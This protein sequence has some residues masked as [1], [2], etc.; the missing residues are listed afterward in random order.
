MLKVSS[1]LTDTPSQSL[2]P[3]ID[4]SVNDD[5]IKM[6][7]F[8]KYSFFQMV[9]VADP[10]AVDS[11]QNAPECKNS[12]SA[13]ILCAPYPFSTLNTLIKNPVFF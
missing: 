10:S 3:L 13:G 7:P 4:S 5:V 6:V 1:V 8:L 9:D 11:L 2:L 12:F